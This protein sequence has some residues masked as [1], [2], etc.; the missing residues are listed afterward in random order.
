MSDELA[1]LERAALTPV[2][3]RLGVVQGMS[4]I[5]YEELGRCLGRLGDVS[6]F[7]LGDWINEGEHFGI[8]GY[9]QAL[10]ATG[11]EADTLDRYA[12]AAER[13]PPARRRPGVPY[14]HH[15]LIGQRLPL[16]PQ[17]QSDWLE[18]A[19]VER[20]SYGELRARL[21]AVIGK[22]KPVE[23][24]AW[25]ADSPLKPGNR[26]AEPVGY[27]SERG[28]GVIPR[29][30][31]AAPVEVRPDLEQAAIAVV[32]AASPH[33]RAGRRSYEIPGEA[34]E[35]LSRACGQRSLL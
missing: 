30:R 10:A 3:L 21:D 2:G 16:A 11:L 6:R 35:R 32:R 13:I 28:V 8:E 34:F 33:T 24:P 26:A 5:E 20:L 15:Q 29:G 12:R 1:I 25:S 9:E 19:E 17:E 14:S 31:E 18:L 4:F 27:V 23:Q 22:A 7:A